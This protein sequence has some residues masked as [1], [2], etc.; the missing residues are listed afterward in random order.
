M[1]KKYVNNLLVQI[2]DDILKQI[3]YLLFWCW[4]S[5]IHRMQCELYSVPDWPA[6]S[7]TFT[8]P[9]TKLGQRSLHLFP[10]LSSARWVISCNPLFLSFNSQ[11]SFWSPTLDMAC[12]RDH[13]NL[14]PSSILPRLGLWLSPPIQT[15]IN[16][17]LQYCSGA[18]IVYV[19][20]RDANRL[21]TLHLSDDSSYSP[22]KSCS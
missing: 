13:P 2:R 14:A 18:D 20:A 17:G 19:N 1:I 5:E 6:A 21:A 8:F 9:L 4:L 10:N 7:R 16:V 11:P 22:S 12:G 3:Q 15:L